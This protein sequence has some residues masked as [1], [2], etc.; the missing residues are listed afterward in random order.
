MRV[1][2]AGAV[3]FIARLDILV[4]LPVRAIVSA[5]A[6]CM[7]NAGA[8]YKLHCESFTLAGDAASVCARCLYL[9]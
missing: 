9:I 1:F 2:V 5:G 7:T 8:L 6:R 4:V 3:G